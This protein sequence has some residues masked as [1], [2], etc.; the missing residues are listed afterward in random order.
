MILE[1]V[2]VGHNQANCYVLGND[3]TLEAI[4]IDPGA[5]YRKIKRVLDNFKL[6]ARYIINTHGHADHIGANGE[7]SAPVLIHKDDAAFLQDPD[8]NLS[9][10][11]GFSVSFSP[12]ERLLEDGE[13]LKLIGFTLD[14]IHT[15]GHTPGGICIKLG[16]ALFTGDTLFA[17]S[18]GRTDFPY[19][20]EEKLLRSVR[21]KILPL[22]DAVIIYPGHGESSTIGT[23]RKTNPFLL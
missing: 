22:G 5:D 2:V 4:L 15:P 17:G 23:E 13:T 19:S 21:A 6:N 7:F 16:G 9:S 14:I 18:V 12:A 3:A 1:R 11:F 8:M 20:S 10:W